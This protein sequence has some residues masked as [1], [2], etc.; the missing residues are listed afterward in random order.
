MN[1]K[2]APTNGTKEAPM[3]DGS[4]LRLRKEI[5]EL[6]RQL[7]ERRLLLRHEAEPGP[8][9]GNRSLRIVWVVGFSALVL[10]FSA[11][12]AGYIPLHR[13]ES[14]LVAEAKMQKETL[15]T[16]SVTAVQRSA[17]KSEL[18]LPGS[19]QAITEAPVLARTSGYLKRRYVDIGDRVAAG[20]LLAE[21]EA[22]ELDQ[23]VQQ[24]RDT[25]RQTQS[26]LEQATANHE[27]GKANLELARVTAERWSRLVTKG[28]VS[29]QENDQ[30]QAQYQA[31]SA[32]V[33]AL[34]K[35][36]GV[37]RNNVSAAESNL[38]RLTELQSYKRIRAPF[39]GVIT[40]RNV[41]VGALITEGNTLLFRVAQTGIVRTYVNVPQANAENIRAG[42]P[43]QL[44]LPDLSG[45][46]FTGRVS[47]TA[48]AMDP[49]SRT[50]LTEVQV[51]NPDGALLP[52]MYAQVHLDT[53][54]EEP[55]LLI[56]G[57]AVVIRSDGIRVALVGADHAIHFQRIT[58][59]RDYG[60]SI[61][62]LSGL[63]QGQ[64]VIVNPSDVVREGAKVNPIP[65][66]GK[67]ATEGRPSGERSSR[68]NADPR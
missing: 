7:E 47:R 17:A 56:R 41:D 28:A 32:N 6:E 20:Q 15:P 4:E 50:L 57:D 23:Q 63:K 21:I 30:Y 9:H 60:D 55:P 8:T 14:M 27:Q 64:S 65:V 36:I 35:A 54:R 66:A 40:L 51:P 53:I 49:S 2:D 13:R 59:G 43:A 16:V 29:R 11:F 37:A 19:I 44:I 18:V 48:G 12:L 67:P 33:K 34:E 1:Y 10:L 22:P 61:E 38:A 45:R 62:V 31:Q 5:E 42:Q 3:T 46:R 39:S 52:G 24:A 68:S 58:V 26:A 25:L